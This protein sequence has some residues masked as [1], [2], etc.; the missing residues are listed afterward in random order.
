MTIPPMDFPL[1]VLCLDSALPEPFG[2]LVLGSH[3]TKQ[4]ML[5]GQKEGPGV[6]LQPLSDGCQGGLDL[7]GK[8]PYAC[9]L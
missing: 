9:A 6:L 4:H 7:R 2:D 3:Q 5:S 8:T 1:D